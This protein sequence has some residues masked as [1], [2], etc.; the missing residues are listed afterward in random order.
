MRRSRA[1][2]GSSSS[3][4]PSIPP[5]CTFF[6]DPEGRNAMKKHFVPKALC[7]AVVLCVAGLHSATS[8]AG[9]SNADVDS[10]FGRYIAMELRGVVALSPSSGSSTFLGADGHFLIEGESVAVVLGGRLLAGIGNRQI[11]LGEIGGRYFPQ[12]HAALGW[13][14]GGGGFYGAEYVDGLAF[15]ISHV[16]GVYAEGGFELPRTFPL[17]LTTS[18]RVDLGYAGVTEFSR[19]EP[20]PLFAMASLNL[21]FLFGGSSF[22]VT[23]AD[24]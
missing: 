12:E 20:S 4:E 6:R 3:S 23:R 7:A 2:R 14:A 9:P 1:L 18:L 11:A 17:R 5:R 15:A 21:G 13:F 10:V 19:I 16:G 8:Q 24:R 22:R